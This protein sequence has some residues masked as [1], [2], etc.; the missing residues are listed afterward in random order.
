MAQSQQRPTG[1]DPLAELA[2]LIGQEDPFRELEREARALRR[3]EVPLTAVSPAQAGAARGASLPARDTRPSAE[4]L[5][6]SAPGAQP[7]GSDH[8]S[9]S[10]GHKTAESPS[11]GVDPDSY[12]EEGAIP[13]D[14]DDDAMLA[15]RRRGGMATVAAVLGLAVIGAGG[16]YGY[17]L[18]TRPSVPAIAPVIKASSEP[19]KVLPKAQSADA[20]SKIYDRVGDRG[21]NDKLVPREEQPLDVKEVVGTASPRIPAASA[22]PAAAAASGAA[23]PAQ[24]GGTSTEPK[25][26]KTIAIRPDFS[27][28]PTSAATSARPPAPAAQPAQPPRAAPTVAMPAAAPSAPVQTAAVSAPAAD[29]TGYLVQVSS[30][31]SEADAEASFRSLQ[32]KYPNLLGGWQPIIRRADLGDKGV[33]YRA[34]IGPFATADQAQDVCGSLRAAGAQCLVQKN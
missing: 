1:N 15:P 4:R 21:Q 31:R 9:Q 29:L 30:Q 20:Q 33:F 6:T 26:V 27:V 34:Q 18:W 14:E 28:A 7:T 12:Y 19:A 22:Q 32:A 16:V 23:A 24:S 2:R 25:K 17:W 3:R 11:E 10:A 8:V 13:F 5:A